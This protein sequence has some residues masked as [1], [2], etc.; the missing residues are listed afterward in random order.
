MGVYLNTPRVFVPDQYLA[1]FNLVERC[2]QNDPA[3]L[4]E[5]QQTNRGPVAAF[6]NTRGA[7]SVEAQETVDMLWADLVM[8]TASGRFPLSRYNGQCSILTFINIVALNKLHD[9]KKAGGRHDRRY[10]SRDAVEFAE[11]VADSKLSDYPLLE[12][13]RDAV[14]FGFR[15]CEAE[16][17]VIVYLQYYHD[18][19]RDDLKHMFQYSESTIRRKLEDARENFRKNILSYV[20]ERDPWLELRWEDFVELCRTTTLNC[21]ASSE[22]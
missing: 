2:L 14:A 8:P 18:L 13:A 10:P 17:F 16:A 5:L 6:L 4:A 11:P 12:L 3:A 22:H 19:D 7:T 1:D 21:L 9:R 20:H 15:Q